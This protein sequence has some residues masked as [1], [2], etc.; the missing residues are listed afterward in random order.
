MRLLCTA[1]ERFVKGDKEKAKLPQNYIQ[2]NYIIQHYT[3]NLA[4]Y[5][6][7]FSFRKRFWVFFW[8][9]RPWALS[10]AQEVNGAYVSSIQTKSAA[11]SPSTTGRLSGSAAP[12]TGATGERPSSRRMVG[13]LGSCWKWRLFEWLIITPELSAIVTTVETA[14]NRS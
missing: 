4:N 5:Q 10:N 14:D 7:N 11:S 13:I 3:I 12:T 2:H 6:E 9:S 8:G 1:K